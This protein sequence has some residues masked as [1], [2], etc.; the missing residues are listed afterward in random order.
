[1]S[2]IITELS[3][4]HK[5]FIN[6]VKSFCSYIDHEEIV[7]EMYI[8]VHNHKVKNPDKEINLSYIWFTL[9]SVFLDQM[10]AEQRFVDLDLSV[11]KNIPEQVTD[12]DEQLAYSQ[13]I[14][15][16]NEIVNKQHYFDAMLFNIYSKGDT[17]IRKLAKETNIST[18]TIF[19]SL[20]QTKKL[21]AKELKEDYEDYK[22]KDYEL[23]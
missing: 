12:L 22:N 14:Q 2:Q 23:I 1:M 13:V 11:F 21:I 18:R 17:S 19:W 20:Q 9:R 3:K 10:R 5:D 6:I 15:K 4:N 8:K 16:Q 7:Q